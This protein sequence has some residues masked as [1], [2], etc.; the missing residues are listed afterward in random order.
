MTEAAQMP[1]YRCHKIVHALKI[2]GIHYLRD[3]QLVL[4]PEDKRFAPFEVSDAF[5]RKHSPAAPGYYV[6]YEDGYTSWSPVEAFENGYTLIETSWSNPYRIAERVGIA[7]FALLVLAALALVAWFITITESWKGVGIA[8]L[9]GVGF[10]V[11][12]ILYA[13]TEDIS[14]WWAR[15]RE[16]WDET[17]TKETS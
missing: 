2:E 7:L 15:K 14:D 4:L 3:G 5:R 11:A 10:F 9:V 8:A 6:V 12:T 13:A 16:A 1:R 17:H